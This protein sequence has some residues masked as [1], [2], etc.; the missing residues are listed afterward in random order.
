MKF[1]IRLVERD[2]VV[3]LRPGVSGKEGVP[4]MD[5]WR[6]AGPKLGRCVM[7]ERMKR[8]CSSIEG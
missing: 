7:Y 6:L 5:G 3:G 1:E 2:E 4:G 8:C